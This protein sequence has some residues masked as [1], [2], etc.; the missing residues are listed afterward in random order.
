M[1][2]STK[3]EK[4]AKKKKRSELAFTYSSTRRRPAGEAAEDATSAARALRDRLQYRIQF[5]S[6]FGAGMGKAGGRVSGAGS[7]G[8]R[9]GQAHPDGLED[10]GPL[11]DGRRGLRFLA[12]LPGRRQSA[13]MPH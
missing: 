5:R 3:G 1:T 13:A 7:G 11:F 4:G 2:D 9:H 10:M 6:D 12:R 8:A